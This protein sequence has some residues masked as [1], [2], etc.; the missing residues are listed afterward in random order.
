MDWHKR[1]WQAGGGD[2][3]ANHYRYYEY[4]YDRNLWSRLKRRKYIIE[5]PVDP[6]SY[7]TQDQRD[8]DYHR[9]ILMQAPFRINGTNVLA[10]FNDNPPID[11]VVL[12]FMWH[13]HP[14]TLYDWYDDLYLQARFQN[15]GQA[16]MFK[17][18]FGGK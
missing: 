6:D 18:V 4:A 3:P 14:R 8:T 7:I 12:E 10:W 13:R 11:S 1:T 17:L 5:L 2:D 16:I 9:N 15:A